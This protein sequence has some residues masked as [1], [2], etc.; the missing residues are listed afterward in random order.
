[1]GPQPHQ[2]S[3]WGTRVLAGAQAAVL[4]AAV[5]SVPVLRTGPDPAE[6]TAAR[7]TATGPAWFPAPV[8]EPPSPPEIEVA[9]SADVVTGEPVG[10]TA[11]PPVPAAQPVPAP[12][13]PTETQPD[14]E[15]RGREALDALHYP[16]QDLGYA[17]RFRAGGGGS[18]LGVTDSRT[19][20]ITIFVRPG[21]SDLSL[22]ATVAHEL[23][24]A[25]DFVTGDDTQRRRY[26]ELRGLPPDT[27]WFPCDR[28]SDYASGAGDW[29]E[30]FALWL[31]GPGD[32][33]SELAGPP[34]AATLERIRVLFTPPSQRRAEP[35]PQPSPTPSPTKKPLLPILS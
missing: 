21:Q 5:V 19:R 2:P 10:E 9:T 35:P 13:P 23:G 22:R 11:P 6:S 34:D 16:W 27:T 14:P 33:R 4:A 20:T 29:A 31:V 18:L 7:V 3:S 24:H 12:R 15:Q 1:L 17:I 8:T 28:C 32:F 26:L 30:V 25:L